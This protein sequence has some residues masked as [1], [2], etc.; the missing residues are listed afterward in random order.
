[1]TT[2]HAA[3]F[4]AFF[5]VGLLAP[6]ARAQTVVERSTTTTAE[7]TVTGRVTTTSTET[8]ISE[9]APLIVVAEEP[10]VVVAPAPSTPPSV[11]ESAGPALTPDLTLRAELTMSGAFSMPL[12]GMSAR[13]GLHGNDGWGGG[14]VAGYFG[15]LGTNAP[16]ELH[17]A[18]EAWRDFGPS[19]LVA[20]QLLGRAGTALVLEATGPSPRVLAQ[21]GIGARVSVDSRIAILLDARGEL[22]VRPA[23]V[24]VDGR[25]SGPELAGGFVMTLGL[26][27]RLD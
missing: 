10:V 17:L 19:D 6:S 11:V 22:R 5:V 2:R 9:P 14:L 12:G 27:I 23:D 3:A 24:G 1:M 18:L 8:V 16:S 21:L 20:F 7:V 26:A 15:E 4:A 13:F 25:P